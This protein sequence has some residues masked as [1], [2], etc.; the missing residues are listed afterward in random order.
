MVFIIP[1]SILYRAPTDDPL[2]SAHVVSNFT[3][4]DREGRETQLYAPDYFVGI[5]AC[6]DQHQFCNGGACTPLSSHIEVFSSSSGLSKT[7]RSIFE[8]LQLFTGVSQ[9]INGRSGSALRASETAVNIVQNSLTTN[10]WLIELSSWFSTG[11][12]ILQNSIR[13]Y[14]SPTTDS[15]P[16]K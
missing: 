15:Q 16:G 5:V 8:R 13:R 7:Q 2:F 14:A 10:Q 1:N 4:T 6:A 11:L 9:V 3:F 12:M